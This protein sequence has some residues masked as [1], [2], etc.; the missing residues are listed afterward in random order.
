MIWVLPTRGRPER[1][2]E[3]LDACVATGMRSRGICYI[4]GAAEPYAGVRWPANWSPVALRDHH[5]LAGVLRRAFDEWPDE[6]GYG[7]SDRWCD[8]AHAGMG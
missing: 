1:C 8:P 3:V 4:D 2:Q 7:L 6:T 5:E